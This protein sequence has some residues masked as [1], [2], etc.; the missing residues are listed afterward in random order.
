MTIGNTTLIRV[1][2]VC[3]ATGLVVASAGFGAVF[4]YKV[5]IQHG[6]LLAGLSILMAVALEGVKPIA[7]SSGIEAL[8]NYRW[9][10]SVPLLALGGIS[11]AYSLTAELSLISMS[12]GDLVAERQSKSKSADRIEAEL[13]AIGIIRPS[14]A[15]QGELAALLS[16]KRLNDCQGWLESVRLRTTCIEKVAPL[17]AE[18]ANAERREQLQA[19]L[20]QPDAQPSKVADPGSVALATYLRAVGLNLSAEVVA[21]WLILVP[22]L[23]L[24]VGSALAMVLVQSSST[25]SPTAQ[26]VTPEPVEP[27]RKAANRRGSPPTSPQGEI[28]AFP[29]PTVD[30]STVAKAIVNQLQAAGGSLSRSERGLAKLIGTSKPTARR[31]IHGLAAAGIIAL[32]ASRSG[33]VMRLLA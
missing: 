31:A 18:L 14:Q 9:G 11:V 27:P 1:V 28:S 24:E 5:G 20:A 13:T 16:D 23:A 10:I 7:I 19:S 2:A 4:A 29:E 21:Q 6:I 30:R 15:V 33:T 32:E 26:A 12:R 3:S 17:K 8:R 25:V 22:V